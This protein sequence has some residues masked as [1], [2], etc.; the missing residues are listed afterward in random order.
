MTKHQTILTKTKRRRGVVAKRLPSDNRF[1]DVSPRM[2]FP[3]Q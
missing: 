1:S 3:G 2:P